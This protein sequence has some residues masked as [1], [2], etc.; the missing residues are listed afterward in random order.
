MVIDLVHDCTFS[1]LCTYCTNSR[2]FTVKNNLY[3]F[4]STFILDIF[5]FHLVPHCPMRVMT[6]THSSLLV[7]FTLNMRTMKCHY[8]TGRLGAR[9]R[10]F[11]ARDI[12]F[13]W[14]HLAH[15]KFWLSPVPVFRNFQ[16]RECDLSVHLCSKQGS[17]W[18]NVLLLLLLILGVSVCTKVT[19]SLRLRKQ[20]N[21]AND[22][23][24]SW[25]QKRRASE[26][27]ARTRF[28]ASSSSTR[29]SINFLSIFY[30]Q[31]YTVQPCQ[32]S[33]S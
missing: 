4:C 22:K 1:V 7:L 2:P 32:R 28:N 24:A 9:A 16:I 29:T 31:Q 21:L 27:P 10:A 33:T 15:E 26:A 3:S 8:V 25:T 30:H 18:W 12:Y 6:F 17:S 5:T 19:S 13:Y 11:N 14:P 23:K 20:A